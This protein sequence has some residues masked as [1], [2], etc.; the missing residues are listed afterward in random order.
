MWLFATDAGRITGAEGHKD[1]RVFAIT[2]EVLGEHRP[3]SP[4][5]M[6]KW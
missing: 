1:P 2:F 4:A 6:E 3:T 5:A